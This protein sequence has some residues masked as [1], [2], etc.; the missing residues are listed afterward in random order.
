MHSLRRHSNSNWKRQFSINRFERSQN[1][2]SFMGTFESQL[3]K[4]DDYRND[5]KDDIT[6]HSLW[7][8]SIT[9]WKRQ[10]SIEMIS[11]M[12]EPY[13]FCSDIQIPTEID[14]SVLK[15]LQ[16]WHNLTFFVGTFK[17]R[18]KKQFN[19]EM[20]SKTTTLY[21]LCG[22]IQVSTEKKASLVLKWFQ[23]WQNHGFFVETFKFQLKNQFSIVMIST[24]KELY[25]L[26]GD[27]QVPTEKHSLLLKWLQRWKTLTFFVGTI[28]IP[29]EKAVQYPN[30]F[31]DDRTLHRLWGH[32]NSNWKRQFS[33]EMLSNITE[34]YI[35][36]WDIQVPNEKA[37]IFHW[38]I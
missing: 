26:C 18:L 19:I 3:K 35:L 1:F 10:F 17:F 37:Y 2:T 4:P 28:Q 32:S 13:I 34:L 9:N 33:T 16:R 31:K 14:S 21:I 12:K 5:Y 6:L 36:C 38:D 27:I 24:I 8:H 29:V 11:N 22:D 25:I 15:W 20:I 23:R 30:D 7:G